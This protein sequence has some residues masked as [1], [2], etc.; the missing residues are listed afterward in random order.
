MGPEIERIYERHRGE[1]L[2]VL[3]VSSG[4]EEKTVRT[5]LAKRPKQVPVYLDVKG[6]GARD[7]AVRS[8]P[9]VVILDPSGKVLLQTSGYSK[10]TMAE[11]NQAVALKLQKVP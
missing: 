6:E 3:A 2:R 9:T 7:F 8:L 11:I 5:F 10:E 1:G 4:E